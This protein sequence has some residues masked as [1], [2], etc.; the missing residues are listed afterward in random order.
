MDRLTTSDEELAEMA[1]PRDEAVAMVNLDQNAVASMP[2]RDRDRAV[3]RS[4]ERIAKMAFVVKTD[5]TRIAR[6]VEIPSR[7]QSVPGREDKPVVG[8]GGIG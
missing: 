3:V 2:T 4:I 1:V 6:V 7:D 5:V 8:A